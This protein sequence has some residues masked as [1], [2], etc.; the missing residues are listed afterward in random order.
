MAPHDH[1]VNFHDSERD[2]AAVL[3]P[4]VSQGLVRDETVVVVATAEHLVAL[5]RSL[6]QLGWDPVAERLGGRLVTLDAAQMLSS[7]MVDDTPDP[8]A[9]ARTIGGVFDRTREGSSIRVFGEM[10]ALLWDEANVSAALALEE[11]WNDLADE[12][13]FTLLCGYPHAV[14]DRDSLANVGRVCELHSEVLTPASYHTPGLTGHDP[15][16]QETSWAFLPVP[17]A[18]PALRRFVSGTLRSWGEDHLVADAIL[19]TSEMATNAI[20]HA[21]SP[22][23]ASLVRAAGIVRISIEDAGP[24]KATQRTA[25]P[26]DLSG[27]GLLIVETLAARWGHGDLPAGKVVWAEFPATA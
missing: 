17:R 13:Q 11:L 8:A 26:D 24:G 6:A 18:I 2:A 7:F 3:G 10:V 4:Y 12:R 23:H 15:R 16:L 14:L 1:A 9:F 25:D 21:D 20:N 19:V 27:R 5:D 22:F